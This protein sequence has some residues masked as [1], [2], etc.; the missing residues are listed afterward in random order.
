LVS[1]YVYFR[2][3]RQNGWQKPSKRSCLLALKQIKGFE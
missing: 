2:R 3:N 1:V